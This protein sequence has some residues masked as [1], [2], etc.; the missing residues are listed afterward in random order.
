MKRNI[1]IMIA[2]LLVLTLTSCGNIKVKKGEDEYIGSNYEEVISELSGLGFS[3][4]E[5]VEIPDL[6]SYSDMAD[7][8]VSEVS[9]NGTTGFTSKTSFPK[10]STI[11]VTYHIIKKIVSPVSL[12]EIADMDISDISELF[13]NAGFI[14]V[15]NKEVYD[16]DPDVVNDEYINEITVN[17]IAISEDGQEIPFDADIVVIRHY[18]YEKYDVE[19]KVD[20]VGNFL[21]SK[22]DVKL[23]IDEDD[24][25]TMKHGEDW[26][27]KL[28][29]KKGEHSIVFQKED[30]TSIIGEVTLDITNNTSVE[31]T[32]YCHMDKISVDTDY[33][34]VEGEEETN[35]AVQTQENDDNKEIDEVETK[36]ETTE[37]KEV[38]EEAEYEKMLELVAEQPYTTVR[39]LMK[40]MGYEAQYE[41]ENTHADFTGELT[42]YTDDELNSSGFIVT[43]IKEMDCQ[44]KT[45]TLYVNTEEN[46]ERVEKQKSIKQTLEKNFDPSVAVTAMESYGKKLYP[47]GFELHKVTGRLAETAVDENT[48]FMKYT[49]KV[50]NAFGQKAEMTCEAKIK[51]PESNPTVYDFNVY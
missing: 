31:Y 22:Y 17:Q 11:T 40:E 25:V 43:G 23:M 18:P 12:S 6:T 3:N 8:S 48:W 36:Q 47:Y 49:C 20:F 29:L 13:T 33:I 19:F 14:N 44:N 15:Q 1:L 10:D 26:E 50:T 45:I 24:M 32:I 35:N 28:R 16:L 27:E 51:G 42:Y 38:D 34:N 5:K 46:R 2:V 9:I 37:D 30:D 39:D 4:I 7:G 21:F 41:H